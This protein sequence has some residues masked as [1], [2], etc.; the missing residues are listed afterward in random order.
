VRRLSSEVRVGILL[1]L[2]S[3]LLIAISPEKVALTLREN[4][5]TSI[6][7]MLLTII[8]VMISVAIHYWVPPDF[9]ERHLSKNKLRHLAYA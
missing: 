6:Q 7:I 1:L 2:A 8:A 3:G 9:A 4:I 5:G